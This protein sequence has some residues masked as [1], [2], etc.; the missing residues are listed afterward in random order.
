MLSLLHEFALWLSFLS[1]CATRIY[2]D[3]APGLLVTGARVYFAPGAGLQRKGK[4]HG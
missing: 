2:F 1:I 4:I 3:P